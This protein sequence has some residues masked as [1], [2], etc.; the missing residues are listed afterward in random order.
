MTPDPKRVEAAFSASLEK[1][2][3]EERAAFLAESCAGDPALR[4]RV[5][6]LLKAHQEA[7]SFLQGPG[8]APITED[9]QAKPTAD[10]AATIGPRTGDTGGPLPGTTVRYIGDYELLE[11]IARGGMGVVYRARQISLNR[12]VAVKM[13][14]AGQLASEADVQRFKTEAEAAASLDHPHLVPIYEVG[15]HEGQHF[16]SMKLV[17]GGSLATQAARPLGQGPSREEQVS[18]ARLVATV[19]RA[20]HYAHQRGILHR[21]LKPANI[22]LD[23]QGEPHVTDFGLAKRVEGG[24]NLTGSGTAMGTPSYMPPEQARG[25]KGL[26]TAVDVYSLGAILYELLTCRP[27]FRAESPVLTLLQV[28]EQEPQ[29]PSSV[30][31]GTPIDRDLETI[32]LKCL[33][34][35]PAGRYGSA[36]TLAD[37]LERWLRGEPIAARPV[38]RMERTLMWARRHPAR[39][40]AALLVVALILV[41]GIGTA[42]ASLWLDADS[43]RKTADEQRQWAES[44]RVLAVDAQMKEQHAKT[45]LAAANEKLARYLYLD[46]IALAWSAFASG[47]VGKARDLMAACETQYRGWEWKNLS[48]K[49]P[50]E[51]ATLDGHQHVVK[52]VSFSPDRRTLASASEDTTVR[53]WDVPSGRELA[54]L[55]GHKARIA[56][57]T[58]SPEG[59]TLASASGDK[60]VKLWDV[61]GRKEVATLVGHK[62]AVWH[63]SF[64]PDGRTLASA[65]EDKTV[66]LWD[67]ASGKE[68]S[69]LA[70]DL[71]SVLQVSFSP[72]GQTLASASG[73]RITLWDTAGAQELAT[74]DGHKGLVY[75]LS[76]SPDG[77]TLASASNDK[78]VKLWDVAG[79]KELATL[80]GHK[81][82]VWHVSFSPDGRILA[83]ASVDKTVKLWHVA[84]RKELAMLDRH[85]GVVWHVSFSP[86]GRTLASASDD[87]TVRLW[88]VASG[89]ELAMLD[90]HKGAVWRVS[91]SPDGRTLAS[92]G[93]DKTVRLWDAVRSKDSAT[94][95]RHKGAVRHVNFSSDGRTLASASDDK[96]VR[97]WDV[98]SGKELATLAGHK[99]RVVHVTFSPDGRTLVSASVDKTM[100][101]WDV[102]SGKLLATLDGHK[103]AVSYVSFSPDGRTMASASSDKTVKLW[104][105][106]SGKELATLAGHKGVVRYVSFS[107]DGRTLASVS[108]GDTVKLWDVASAKELA[109]LT[110]ERYMSFSPDGRTLALASNDCTL[111]LW[112]VASGRARALLIGHKLPAFRVSFSPDGRTLASVSADK[113]IRIWDV[114]SAK[115]LAMAASHN[116]SELDVNFSPDGRTLASAGSDKMVKAWDVATGKHL[117]TIHEH[118]KAVSYVS[119]SH[120]GR[121]LASASLDG[122]VKLWFSEVDNSTWE[123]RKKVWAEQQA[124]Q[125]FESGQWFAASFHLRQLLK[126]RPDDAELQRQLR[127]AETEWE[128]QQK[129][130]QK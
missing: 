19:A 39:A 102:A 13:I 86:D 81:G 126:E 78:T 9:A 105:S 2:S 60:T 51:L 96:T 35:V 125:A 54:T 106:A 85:R 15:E 113:S 3:A 26:T 1:T 121:T 32:C 4:Q 95:D 21:D 31:R 77:R 20:V 109:V 129:P 68:L 25:D 98:P 108:F 66:K 69:T 48:L 130:K 12:L 104:E 34:K 46:R 37:D 52:H 100:K 93:D 70:A 43:A 11:V 127:H 107:P 112:D 62:G 99:D 83:S 40:T 59:R 82:V 61:P 30:N 97:L 110:G 120:D 38:G 53:L 65:S 73:A 57:V 89:K 22:L 64:S 17:E 6:A 33:S 24:S 72:D 18:A 58:F 23:A 55:A 47:D 80:V 103:D 56:H 94:L 124:T 74:L 75:Q 123:K 111:K 128:K 7:S 16:F 122:T 101:L 91:F 5:E 14:L 119:F 90:G 118:Q 63:I 27:P 10:N 67:V 79:R 28:I 117:A 76:F 114:P 45:L 29:S 116:G 87:E 115:E 36:E 44:A 92:A 42:F 84:G 88:D 8:P 41:V 49:I 50:K 71:G